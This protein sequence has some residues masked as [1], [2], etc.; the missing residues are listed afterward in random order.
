MYKITMGFYLENTKV[1]KTEIEFVLISCCTCK[2]PHMLSVALQSVDALN[3]YGNTKVELLVVDNDENESAR[4]VVENFSQTSKIPVHY[5]CE[6]QRGIAFARNRVLKEAVELNA[7]HIAFFDDDE[8]LDKDWL[9]NHIEFYKTNDNVIIS[10]GPTYSKFENE[11]PSYIRNNKIFKTSTTKKTGAIRRICASGNVFFPVSVVKDAD[12]WFDNRFVF[13]GGEDG[14]F[15]ARASEAGYTIVWN[16]DAVNYEIIG[17][18]RANM[19][20]ILNRYY[21]NGYSGALLR[22]KN[23]KNLFKKFIYLFKTL[24]S[25]SFMALVAIPSIILGV[26]FFWNTVGM[27]AKNLGKIVSTVRGVPLDYYKDVNGN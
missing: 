10:S 18:Q 12:L 13:M 1:I 19:H 14:D 22:F 26:S 5:V 9:I 20:W 21:Y 16:N 25:F 3:F 27:A 7:S 24:V 2:R 4:T 15:F 23:D 17:D 11:Y 8:T 6:K